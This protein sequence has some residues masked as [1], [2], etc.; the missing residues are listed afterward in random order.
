MKYY[1]FIEEEQAN[2]F[3][4]DAYD[5]QLE[6]MK[7]LL[8]KDFI[9]LYRKN[10][11]FHDYL[12]KNVEMISQN[13]K[14][15]TVILTLSKFYE[16]TD[17]IIKI[18]LEDVSEFQWNYGSAYLNAY[19]YGEISYIKNHFNFEIMYDESDMNIVC[20]NIKIVGS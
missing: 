11:Y 2:F 3:D 19:L 9:E 7:N 6:S 1:R 13:K 5:N 18:V 12:L 16:E 20:Q 4:Y 8:E 15:N 17:D 14:K 10:E